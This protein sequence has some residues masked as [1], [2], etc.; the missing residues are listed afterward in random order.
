MRKMLFLALLSLCGA[1]TGLSADTFESLREKAKG[2]TVTLP[3]G[4]TLEAVVV[5]D[6]RSLNMSESPQLSYEKVDLSLNYRTAYIQNEAGT[7]GMRVIFNGIYD[8]RLPRF[9]R[10][11]ISLE[12]AVLK[13]ETGPER[14]TLSNVD[15]AMCTVLSQ[16]AAPAPKLRKIASLKDEDL[17]TFLFLEDVEF[18]SK[19]GSYTNVDELGV[20]SSWINAFRNPEGG[21]IDGSGVY[22]KDNEGDDL[23]ML[24]NTRCAWRRRGGR[25]PQG[26]GQVG[27][28]LVH[29]RLR[30][31]GDIG[32][33]AL[34]PV[35][36]KDIR[37]AAEPAS[38]YETIVEWNWDRNYEDA[39]N[40]ERQGLKTW[41]LSDAFEPD[42]I[43]P[44]V[45][46]GFLS[47]TAGAKLRLDT[48]YNTR[49]TQDAARPGQGGR[50]YAALRL[51]TDVKD[52]YIFSGS[53]LQGAQAIL[54]E[55]STKGFAGK[56]V[57]FDFT[58]SAGNMDPNM[59][60]GYPAEWRVAYSV[61]GRNFIPVERTFLLRP[62][63]YTGT[64]VRDVGTRMLCYDASPGLQ[65]CTVMLPAFLLGQEKVYF[66]IYP[67]SDK[68]VVLP[69]KP[70]DDCVSGKMRPG[71]S[72]SFVIRVGKVS[73]RAL[74]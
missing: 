44:D 64:K 33:Y 22:L 26:I 32:R 6:Y 16:G 24:V 34:R 53:T 59:S 13:G 11:R 15:G 17:Y 40:L 51:N 9:A 56:G 35:D 54:V 55:T 46:K 37:V 42:R 38:S 2:R 69:E 10:V 45:G 18:L 21:P 29:E 1:F 61:D 28:I 14:Y 39:L 63:R 49:C 19:E 71:F 60:W 5:S 43:L 7:L 65:E 73:V 30:R 31:Y 25:M 4:A 8:N 36:E 52:W 27:G 66:R 72:H 74:K 41:I 48:E 23:F 47:T 68:L 58:F 50:D 62:F 3:A 20:Q 57:S 70:E 12:G 67:A